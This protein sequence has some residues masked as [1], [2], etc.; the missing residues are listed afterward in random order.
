MEE[1]DLLGEDGVDPAGEVTPVGGDGLGGSGG[2]AG[3][4]W[5]R[6]GSGE[7]S[8]DLKGRPPPTQIYEAAVS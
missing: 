2:G 6:L 1:M 5:R 4:E 3:E 7:K 8:G